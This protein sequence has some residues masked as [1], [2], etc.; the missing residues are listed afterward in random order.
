MNLK[1]YFY[2]AVILFLASCASQVAPTGGIKDI[3][4]PQVEKSNPENLS[5]N[6]H[7]SRISITFDEYVQLNDATNQVFFSPALES[8]PVFKLR[9]KTLL[10]DLPDTLR[11]NTTYTV[12]FGN[13]IKDITEGNIMLSYQYVFSTGSSIDSLRM[14]GKLQNAL[15]GKLKP[16]ILVMLYRNATDDSVVAKQRPDYNARTDTSG[17]FVISHISDGSYKLFALDDQNFNLLYDQ[18]DES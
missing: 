18:P 1:Y 10:I 13:A 17:S 14:Q 16:N 9:G 3:V 7:A 5:V 2:L 6:F 15:G 4:P 11:K 12:N 8:N